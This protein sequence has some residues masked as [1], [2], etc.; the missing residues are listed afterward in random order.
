MHAG[1]VHACKHVSHTGLVRRGLVVK[2]WGCMKR[3][4]KAVTVLLLAVQDLQAAAMQAL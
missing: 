1:E 3:L 4:L 2:G